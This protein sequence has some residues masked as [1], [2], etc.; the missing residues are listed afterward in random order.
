MTHDPNQDPHHPRS[1]PSAS[2][3]TTRTGRRRVLRRRC[4]GFE[5]RMDG[6][7]RRGPA[8]G[9]G[10]AAR[11]DDVDRARPVAR[12]LPGRRRHRPSPVHRRRRGR[13]CGAAG[14][15]RRRGCRDHPVP[16]ADVRLPRSGR[17]PA[18]D[19]RA[20]A[21]PL[22]E[23]N[24]AAAPAPPVAPPR[25]SHRVSWSPWRSRADQDE[26]LKRLGGGRW[27]TRDERFTIEPQI[28]VPGWWSMPSETDRA[29]PGPGS[30]AVRESRGRQGGH[31]R[32]P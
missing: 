24:V 26:S 28:P 13:S 15:R 11:R 27:Q 21:G 18:R 17:Q 12:R 6:T 4:S 14:A 10:R 2:R 30:W 1:G 16:G 9:R 7:V 8:L 29:G 3:S 19:R 22:I 23:R 5:T 31:R 32:R 20:A 25:S